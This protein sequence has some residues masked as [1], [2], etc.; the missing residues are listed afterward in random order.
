MFVKPKFK[1][2]FDVHALEE[3]Y[4]VLLDEHQPRILVSKAFALLAPFLD[5]HHSIGDLSGKLGKKMSLNEIFVSLYQLERFGF[6]TEGENRPTTS[7]NA[8]VEYFKGK[9]D[10]ANARRANHT[11]SLKVIGDFSGDAMQSALTDNELRLSE[12]GDFLVVL[13]DDYLRSPLRKIN[14]E[15]LTAQRPWLLVKPIGAVLWVGPLFEPGET[16]CWECMAQ[17]LG[18]NRQ[19]ERYI[20]KHSRKEDYTVV[21]RPHLPATLDLACNLAATEI[22]KYLISPETSAAYGQ[23]VTLDM[24][25]GESAKHVLVKRPQCPA[26]GD[27]GTRNQGDPQPIRLCHQ[28]K[29][30]W[31]DGGHR[32]RTPQQ[33]FDLY[34]H[35]ISPILGAVS[36]LTPAFGP[37]DDLAP[38]YIAGHNF[39]MG[40]DSVI[41][42]KDSVRG[43]SGGK[44]AS[45]IQAKASGLCE[46]LERYSGNY[47]GDEFVI[48]GSY[49][50]L[51]PKAIHPN[52]C[53]GFSQA[54]YHNREEWNKSNPPSRCVLIA[55]PFDEEAEY[56]WTPLWSL[57]HEEF[58]YLPTAYL[59]YD[60][61]ELKE[62]RWCHPDS[63]GS[64]AG[65]TMEE[66]ILQG[67]MELGERD[68]TALWWYNRIPKPEVDMDSFNLPYVGAI[69]EYYKN[70]ERD[71][72][73]LDISNEIG[74]NT[75][76]CIS[77][78]T[79]REVEDILLGLGSHFDPKIALLRAITEVNQFLPSVIVKNPDGSTL[80]LYGGGLAEDWWKNA[81]IKDHPYLLPDPTRKAKKFDEF[82]NLSSNDL[83]VD[84]LKCIDLAKDCSMEVLVLDQTRVDIGLNVVKVVIPQM[85]HFWRRFGKK[86]LFDQ[87]VR[88][89][90]LSKPNTEE[91]LNTY[92]I[93]F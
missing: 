41:A 42:L 82:I 70:L 35:H 78:R 26:C 60:H 28:E 48:R 23:I 84:V 4:L 31:E 44:G 29:H 63:N 74:I 62:P 93:F 89:G 19:F 43:V 6:I 72:W 36:S 40:L 52:D 65:N 86:R 17:R 18:S 51:S 85:L 50:R 79:D 1:A 45:K 69:R 54:Q 21:S 20:Q 55:S 10:E 16:G 33:T 34:K 75:F 56:D 68:S 73:C 2:P 49:R 39:S 24:V 71:L 92:S 81:V 58:K 61:P 38:C 7:V 37:K 91:E 90:W 67:F 53:M 25:S 80:Y 88:E 59:Y 64:A 83:L 22:M 11:F 66:A 47:I 13:T 9:V 76:A 27:G 30:Y 87:P 46:A 3:K 15:K 57:T 32:V 12:D 77:R 5:G 8:F 14:A